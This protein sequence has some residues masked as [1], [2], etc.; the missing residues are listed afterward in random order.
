[1][2]IDEYLNR[3]DLERELIA[4]VDEQKASLKSALATAVDDAKLEAL[5]EVTPSELSNRD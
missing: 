2:N 4:L 3:E 1:M 5:E